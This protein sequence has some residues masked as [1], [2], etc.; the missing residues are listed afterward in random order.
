MLIPFRKMQ[1]QGND[2]AILLHTHRTELN[3]PLSRLA[4]DICDR[5]E[6]VGAD[7][8]VIL[9]EDV[10]ADARMV[11]YNSDGSRASM[12]GSALRCCALLMSEMTGRSNLALATDSG[13]KTASIRETRAGKDIEV[14]L[15]RPTL[16]EPELEVEGIGGSLVEVGNLH[17]VSF[18]D[19]LNDQEVRFGPALEKHPA[20]P[21][22]VNCQF[23]CVTGRETL[24]LKIWET[25]C[26]A[27]RACGTG[28]VAS[29]F[30]AIQKGLLADSV[31]VLMPGGE[32]RIN[33]EANGEYT[34]AGGVEHVFNGI[35]L[36]KTSANT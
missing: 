22:A 20:F 36:W 23:A 12:C 35:Y 25:G 8:L 2:F 32:V 29:V 19:G 33:R 11:I 1:A 16:R 30:A 10:E 5:R 15:G 27:T 4:R 28:A 14:N 17:F 9:L 24:E 13:L 34:L 3:L 21:E 18:W 6:G 31:R 7:G 26:G